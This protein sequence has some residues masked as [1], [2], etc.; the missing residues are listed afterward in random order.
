[1]AAR[2]IRSVN[3]QAGENQNQSLNSFTL[4]VIPSILRSMS[5]DIYERLVPPLA[6]AEL[7]TSIYFGKE[8]LSH[9]GSPNL[10]QIVGVANQH[11]LGI[12]RRRMSC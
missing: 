10:T 12:C 7:G 9:D 1:M 4:L 5:K 3:L 6:I 8:P 2:V 11:G